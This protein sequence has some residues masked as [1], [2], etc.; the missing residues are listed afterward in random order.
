MKSAMKIN[1]DRRQFM[2]LGLWVGG[3]SL[4]ASYPVLF[5]RYAVFINKYRIPVPNLPTEFE[6]FTIV[7]LTDLHFGFLVPLLQMQ[8]II[9]KANSIPRDMT[10][11]TGDYVHERN[12]AHQIDTVWPM[13][14]TLKSPFGVLSVLGNHD[15]WADTERS[16][17]WL[18]RTGQ[19]L[20]HKIRK[21]EKNGQ[22]L[23]FVGAGDYWEDHVSIDSLMEPIPEKDCRIILAHNPDSAD[24]LETRANLLISGHTHGGQVNLPFIGTPILPVKNKN[25][26]SGLKKS[27]KG[28]PVF[29]SRGVGWATLPVRFNCYPE[30]AVLQLVK[31]REEVRG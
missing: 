4:I 8:K 2:K 18:A 12:S 19:D 22:S 5:E 13:L 1:I 28:F 24:S 10:V 27:K 3:I 30:I 6:G 9:E 31:S 25:Y 14:A 16:K 26:S 21:I 15:H 7:H 20:Y 23:W 11:C 17:F 29:I